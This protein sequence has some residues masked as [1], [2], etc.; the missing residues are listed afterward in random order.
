MESRNVTT[1]KVII[2]RRS[3][4]V[5]WV[6]LT[7]FCVS[8]LYGGEVFPSGSGSRTPTLPYGCRGRHGVYI[9]GCGRSKPIQSSRR[10]IR[11]KVNTG[12][13]VSCACL[14]VERCNSRLSFSDEML[15]VSCSF[16]LFQWRGPAGWRTPNSRHRF[17]FS[18]RN[19]HWTYNAI[20]NACC[21]IKIV[22]QDRV[23]T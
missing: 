23:A 18:A 2:I 22:P 7:F 12:T 21:P 9:R 17:R 14:A 1:L 5:I 10:R 11:W 3:G 19:K 16:V 15:T 20:N 13:K 6:L 8:S 4:Q